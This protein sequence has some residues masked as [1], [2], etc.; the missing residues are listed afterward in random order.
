VSVVVIGLNHRT[1]PLELLERMTVSDAHLAKALADLVGRDHVPEAV[2]LSTCNRTEIYASVER[3]HAAYQDVRDFLSDVSYLSVDAFSDHLYAHYDADAAGHLFTVASGLDSAVLGESEIQGQVKH[4][5]ERARAE[6]T[7]GAAL[8]MLFRHAVE[9][10]KRVRT[11]TGISRNITSVAHSAVAMARDRLGPLTGSRILVLGAGDMGERMI[12]ALVEDGAAEV[13]VANRTWDRSV[14]LAER[15]GGSPIHLDDLPRSLERVDLLL[16]STGASSIM[17]EHGDLAPV[18]AERGD[19]RPLFIVDIAVPRDVDP[20]AA[21]LPGVTLLDMDDLRAF[22]EAGIEERKREAKA[23][24]TIVDAELERYLSVSSAREVAP[25]V[26]SLRDRVEALRQAELARNAIRLDGLDDGQREA[27]EA[28]TRSVLA[29]VLHE[30][31]VR[32]KE[33]A[34]SDRGERLADSLRAL[35]DL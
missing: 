32:L 29:K 12:S 10:G 35:F 22:A 5:W 13:F 27:V 8:N 17:I 19:D 15:V 18:M 11:D 9:V 2:V 1:V 24:R 3:F 34:G 21:D 33:A 16:T 30:P 26:A 31:T 25:L 6:G 4:A 14:D 7:T 23:A 28:V 20:A